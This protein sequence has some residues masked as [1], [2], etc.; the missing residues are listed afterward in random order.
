MALPIWGMY[1]KSCYEDE[2]LNISK[3][4]FIKPKDLSIIVDCDGYVQ[5]NA[6]N[7]GDLDMPEDDVPDELELF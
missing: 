4:D 2:D 5:D 7:N 1:M 6:T 3:N